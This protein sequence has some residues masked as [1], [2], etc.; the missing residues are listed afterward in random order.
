MWL[1][2]LLGS[3]AGCRLDDFRQPDPEGPWTVIRPAERDPERWGAARCNDGTATSVA[4]RASPTGSRAWVVRVNGGFY[5]DDA[6]LL[7]SRRPAHETTALG[8]T[9]R[10]IPDGG[11]WSNQEY[12]LFL[13]D[14]EKNPLWDANQAI[15]D[16]CTS[17]VWLGE[18]TERRPTTGS[19]D[20]WYFT[21][22]H[23][24]RAGLGSLETVG[25]DPAHPETRLLV[26]GQSAG[27][28]GLTANLPALQDLYPD[29]IAGQRLKV[30]FDGAWIAP[31]PIDD[32]L[33]LNTWGS[34]L[35]PCE[36]DRRTAGEDPVSCLFGPVWYPY[37]AASGIDL[38]VA[39]SGL[40]VTQAKHL[41]VE[42]ALGRGEL[43][44]RTRA[45]LEGVPRVVSG[46][47]AYHLIAFD[48]STSDT[49]MGRA[50]FES[51]DALWQG[52]EAHPVFH[53]Y[54]EPP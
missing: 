20:G 28:V 37:W 48:R 43:R 27:G 18:A 8:P 30:V 12:G 4:Y 25:F 35:A 29:L 21:G 45:T 15:L 23:A 47:F 38:L 42:G 19:P 22:R 24:F 14:P 13:R 17:D 40:D 46:G 53:R 49:A 5:C 44:D 41:G 50:L 1:P 39:Q 51:V 11:R 26:V 9:G 10:P 33:R 34:L 16:Y 54:D 2:L 3:L 6:V 7:C 52:R 36:A 31:V 32:R